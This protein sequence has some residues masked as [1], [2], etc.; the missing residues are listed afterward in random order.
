AR[1]IVIALGCA[2]TIGAL[3]ATAASA[4][5]QASLH[6][7]ASSSGAPGSTPTLSAGGGASGDGPGLPPVSSLSPVAVPANHTQAGENLQ[8]GSVNL[9]SAAQ[10][11]S[12]D[13]GATLPGGSGPLLQS[14]ANSVGKATGTGDLGTPTT[15]WFDGGKNTLDI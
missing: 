5:E 12:V 14:A 4:M 13:V 2:G 7:A 6:A 1:T 9:E 10:G 15:V 8:N 11:A 3:S